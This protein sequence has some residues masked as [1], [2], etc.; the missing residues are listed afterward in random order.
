MF[1]FLRN[2]FSDRRRQ[3]FKFSDGTRTRRVDPFAVLRAIDDHPAWVPHRDSPIMCHADK[4]G[5]EA[6]ATTLQ[7]ISDVFGVK[8]LQDDGSGLT[9]EETIQLWLDFIGFL[10]AL[11]KNIV[12]PQNSPP[13]TVSCQP[14]PADPKPN[15]D[16]GRTESEPSIEKPCHSSMP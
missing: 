16:S 14:E 5:R 4:F 7:G 9:Q 2:L 13:A 6:L 3:I 1:R 11:K 12:T 15:W 8:R 10:N